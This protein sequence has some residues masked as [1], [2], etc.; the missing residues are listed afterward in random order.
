MRNTSLLWTPET[1]A[2]VCALD[3]AS[4]I[5]FARLEIVPMPVVIGD[6]PLWRVADVRRWVKG[7][8]LADPAQAVAA[9]WTRWQ[10]EERA[11]MGLSEHSGK[12]CGGCHHGF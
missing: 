9:L 6:I 8:G 7:L 5:K 12:T 2:R 3:R 1:M 11:V 10:T 4:L